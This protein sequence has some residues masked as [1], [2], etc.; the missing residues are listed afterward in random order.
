MSDIDE[1]LRKLQKVAA[2]TPETPDWHPS[3]KGMCVC[4]HS[5]L[6]HWLKDPHK[7]NDCKTCKG[8]TVAVRP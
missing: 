8:Y 5:W 6:F 3:V 7:C 2:N 1:L 4:G